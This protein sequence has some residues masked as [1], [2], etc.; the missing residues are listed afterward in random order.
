MSFADDIAGQITFTSNYEHEIEEDPYAALDTSDCTY[1]STALAARIIAGWWHGGQGSALYAFAST[2]HFDRDELLYELDKRV[3]DSDD[4]DA[5]VAW[6][7]GA[8]QD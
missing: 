7:T 5:L 4:V 3:D 6:I 8:P 2:G 1:A